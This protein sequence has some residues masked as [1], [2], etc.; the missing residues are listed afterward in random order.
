MPF[1][2]ELDGFLAKLQVRV[3]AAMGEVREELRE[4]AVAAEKDWSD[5]RQH[6]TETFCET[7]A[8]AD[9]EAASHSETPSEGA[10]EHPPE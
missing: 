9:G 6:L 4:M 3:D 10:D 7:T 5:I 1:S 2:T 8:K